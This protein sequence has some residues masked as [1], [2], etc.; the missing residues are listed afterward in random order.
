MY[1]FDN[2]DNTSISLRMSNDSTCSSIRPS[3]AKLFDNIYT[4]PNSDNKKIFKMHMIKESFDRKEVV[5]NASIDFPDWLQ[6]E[7]EY[8]SVFNNTLMLKDHNSF[9]IYFMALLSVFSPEKF[10]VLSRTQCGEEKFQCVWVQQLHHN[11]L[12]FQIGSRHSNSFDSFD[13]CN[14]DTFDENR[15]LTQSS[16]SNFHFHVNKRMSRF[17]KSLGWGRVYQTTYIVLNYRH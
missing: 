6:G 12:D 4:V 11:I 2:A 8:L 17:E 16:K 9:K 7:W 1:H 15:W 5:D 10:I 3:N 14:N 13:L